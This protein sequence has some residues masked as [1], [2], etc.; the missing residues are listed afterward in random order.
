MPLVSVDIN[1]V[2]LDNTSKGLVPVDIHSLKLDDQP[3]KGAFQRLGESYDRRA[4]MAQD[5][6]DAYQRGEQS[7]P[8]T[9]LQITGKGVAGFANDVVGEGVA[10]GFRALPD[11]IE[12]PIRDTASN[13]ANYIVDSPAGGLG[14]SAIA[15]YG[16]FAEEN[17]RAARN[18]EAVANIGGYVS[19]LTPIKGQSVAAR[20]DNAAT[21]AVTKAG[22]LASAAKEAISPGRITADDLKTYA[23]AQYN[24]ANQLG[25]ELKPQVADRF[26]DQLQ[27]IRPQT[28]A[29]QII[30]GEDELSKLIE[31][32]QELRGKPISLQAAQEIDEGLG[33][34]IDKHVVLG[35]PSKEGV[36][37]MEAQRLFRDM[38]ES[39]PE[40]DV[41]GGQEGFQSL[42]E[43]RKVWAAQSSLREVQKIVSRAEMTDNPAI[44]I[45][46][47]FRT[48][49]NNEKRMRGFSAK[50]RIAIMKVA[51][52]SD[53]IDALRTFG[54]RFIAP[55]AA[56]K[57]GP[58]GGALAHIGTSISRKGAT[59]LQLRKA[60][61]VSNLIIDR[62]GVTKKSL[63][64]LL[65]D[66]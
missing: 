9:A 16:A 28:A 25:G 23:S 37:V 14:K 59:G 46:N 54:G 2:K 24:K 61:K 50:E 38:I 33:D 1:Q 64:S 35:K 63:R 60:N 41:I 65:G 30:S 31:R 7:L 5:A 26:V 32:A 11:A 52:A 20:V 42:K 47:G 4:G 17:P 40:G 27:S 22:Q 43:A 19:A 45:K 53:T 12:Q 51:E 66:D 21:G 44:A 39:A 15:K 13:V 58:A 8:E 3:S 56:L 6:A 48:L 36:K 57:F 49:A 29:G 62:S 18:L 34:L 10:A 55:L